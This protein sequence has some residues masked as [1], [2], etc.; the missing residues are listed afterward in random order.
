MF[1]RVFT[2][3]KYMSQMLWVP[4]PI[5]CKIYEAIS[6]NCF[7]HWSA[8]QRFKT[9]SGYIPRLGWESKLVSEKPDGNANLSDSSS[10]HNSPVCIETHRDPYS[11]ISAHVFSQAHAH[12][13]TQLGKHR[14]RLAYKP[15]QRASSLWQTKYICYNSFSS[16]V[17]CLHSFFSH[18]LS[19]SFYPSLPGFQLQATV[20]V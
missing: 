1:K 10:P 15:D 9:F 8:T 14:S 19:F 13:H 6:C 17:P 18:S 11:H 4:K 16:S 2:C 3:S 20:S 12:T 7:R 5:E